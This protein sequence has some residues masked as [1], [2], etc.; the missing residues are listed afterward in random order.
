MKYLFYIN[1]LGTGGAERV[2]SQLANRLSSRGDAVCVVTSFPLDRE[3]SLEEGISRVNLEPEDILR[4][5]VRKNISRIIGL[6]RQLKSFMPDVA[7]SFMQEPNF[8]LVLS[9]L[10]LKCKI[11]VSV[12]NDPPRE[13]PG[14]LGFFVSHFILPMAD[15]CVFQTQDAMRWF[16]TRLQRKSLVIPNVVDDKFFDTDWTGGDSVV[17]LGRLVPQKNHAL[18]IRA[19]AS[20]S[21]DYPHIHLRIYGVGDLR[22]VLSTLIINLCVED[23]VHLMGSTNDVA[24]VLS[25]AA[26]F[27]LSSDYE[28]MPNALMEA[29]AVGVPCIST[30]CPCGGPRMLIENGISGLLVPSNNE[31]AM[32]ESLAL[33]LSDKERCH[34]M[35]RNARQRA[36]SAFRA[37]IV[38]DKWEQCFNYLAHGGRI[39]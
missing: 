30:D 21:R 29:M 14:L 13:Y 34:F 6:R 39:D 22:P 19:F 17:A 35:S 31:H 23:R 24:S 37:D 27:V 18:L 16:P 4:S 26:A 2:V 36:V 20:I 9:S 38:F 3:Y 28:G 1:S 5:R 7:I 25:H 8:R 33:V 15:F 12:R 32:A 10:G 11:L